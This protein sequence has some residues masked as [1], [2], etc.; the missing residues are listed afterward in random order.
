LKAR[1]DTE[2]LGL[3]NPAAPDQRNHLPL[4][5]AGPDNIVNAEIDIAQDTFIVISERNVLHLEKCFP[6]AI[7]SHNYNFV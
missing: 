3:S 6:L 5:Y 1:E 4:L 7:D 2:K